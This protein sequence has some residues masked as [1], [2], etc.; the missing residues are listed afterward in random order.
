MNSEVSIMAVRPPFRADIVG[1]Y[2]RPDYLHQARRDYASG[3]ISKEQLTQVED[4]A[5]REL[6]EKQKSAGLHVVTDGEFRRSFWHIDFLENLNGIEGYVPQSGYN[7]TFHGKAAPSYNIRVVDQLSFNDDHPFLG[8]FTFLQNL[9]GDDESYVAKA[10]IPSPTMIVRQEILANDGSSRVHDIYPSIDDFYQD[11]ARVYREVI[12]AFY[13]VGCRYLQFDDTN[14][15]FLGDADKQRELDQKGINAG[16][17]AWKCSDI[18]NN[19]LQG[20]PDDMVITTHICRG[21]HA[22]SWLFSG[23]YESVAKPLFACHYDGFFLEYDNDRS[24]DFSPLRHWT[25]KESQVVLGLITSKFPQLEDTAEIKARI[26]EA[27]QYVPLDNLCLSPQC[28]FASTEEGNKL[29]EEEQWNK[30]RLVCDIAPQV[31]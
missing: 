1:S 31:W 13:A 11:L 30:I 2:L 6:V 14:W 19:A 4:K 27:T 23:G 24:G 20:K 9:I 15:A 22:S 17:I 29:T 8:H 25:N 26:E 5:I 21:N 3:S 16:E 12:Q 28:G 18:I 10:T 7:Q